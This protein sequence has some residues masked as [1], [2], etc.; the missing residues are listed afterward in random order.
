M[1]SNLSL[2]ILLYGKRLRGEKEKE[3]NLES[4]FYFSSN[5]QEKGDKDQEN[6]LSKCFLSGNKC[7]LRA[8]RNTRQYE[9]R[10]VINLDLTKVSP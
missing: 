2:T 10:R 5:P 6:S 4:M 3:R 7:R 9:Q 1:V 8:C